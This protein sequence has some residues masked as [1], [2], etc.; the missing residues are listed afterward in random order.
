MTLMWAAMRG[1][2]AEPKFPAVLTDDEL[3]AIT[4]PVLLITECTPPHASRRNGPK[5]NSS[6]ASGGARITDRP[7]FARSLPANLRI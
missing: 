5:P 2:R 4:V 1:Y 6:N 3:R 7:L